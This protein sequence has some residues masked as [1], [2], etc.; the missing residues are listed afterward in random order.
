MPWTGT[1]VKIYGQVVTYEPPRPR[2]N[3]AYGI[4]DAPRDVLNAIPGVELVEMERVR[5]AAWCCG[6]GGSA[7]EAYPEFSAWTAGQRIE[8]ARSTGAAVLATACPG[9]KSRLADA[10][11]VDEA[12][13]SGEGAGRSGG[14]DAARTTGAASATA[15]AAMR[16]FD[17]LELVEQAL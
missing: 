16:V 8:E 11:A 3:G 6:A 7:R 9:C 1:E 5:E 10:V 4:Y 2:Y 13:R 12:A 17:V 15:D 14:G